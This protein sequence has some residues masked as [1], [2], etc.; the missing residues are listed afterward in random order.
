VSTIANLLIKIGVDVKDAQ[1]DMARFGGKA[2]TGLRRSL[3]PAIGVLTGIGLAAKAGFGEFVGAQKV[4]AQTN[5]VLKSTGNAANVSVAGIQNLSGALMSKSGVD[6]EVIQ[7]GANMLL[8][9]TNVRNEVGKGNNV[10]DQAT[11]AALDMS[12]ALG[13]DMKSSSMM[14]GKAL[15]DPTKGMTRLTRAGVTFTAAQVKSVKAMQDSGNMAGAQKVILQE[16][17]KEFGGSA[18]AA[19]QTFS[20]QI[21]IAQQ[22]LS[23]L[24]GSIVGAVMPAFMSFAGILGTVANWMTK[25]E[26]ATKVIIAVMGG[27][28]AAVVVAN[29]AL[30]LQGAAV[31]IVTAAKLVASG[32][33]K[34]WTAAQWLLNAAL[35]ANPIGIV[36]VAVM[37][38]VAAIILAYKNSAT[39]RAIVTAAFDAVKTAAMATWNWIKA[40]W[41]LLLAIL[42]GPIGIAIT[43]IVK[44]WD[45]VTVA[46]DAVKGAIGTIVGAI[47][48]VKDSPALQ[49]VDNAFGTVFGAVKSVINSVAAAIDNVIGKVSSAVSAVNGLASR[50]GSVL[51]K[52]TSLPGKL[53][54]TANGGIFNG[55]QARIIGEA[56]PEAVIPLSRPRRAA[57]LLRESGLDTLVGNKGGGPSVHIDTMVVQDATD[58]DRVAQRLGRQLM[59]AAA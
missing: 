51:S 8:T 6:D 23:N 41:P 47:Q 37:G 18:A 58:I 46:V 45:K 44:N 22:T 59:M 57:E 1:A 40:N 30:K 26:T 43:A 14:L 32:A 35:T 34:A 21:A 53:P 38:L 29:V 11:T 19:G 10:F 36:I 9:F 17:S 55:A 52:V 42:T 54:F 13:Q 7:S 39:F 16:L 56:G 31:A 33:T 15:N 27:L 2:G 28:A 25:H 24:A 5:A 50:V 20:G 48:R 3:V 49:A 12:V 4:T